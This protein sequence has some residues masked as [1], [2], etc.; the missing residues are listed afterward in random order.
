MQVFY[1][2]KI[3]KNIKGDKELWFMWLTIIEKNEL[4]RINKKRE[5]IILNI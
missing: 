1:T 2:Y 5:K 3:I 4:N